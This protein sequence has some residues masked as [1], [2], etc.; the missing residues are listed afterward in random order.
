MKELSIKEIVI[1]LV[2]RIDPVG[3]TI[4][5][6]ARLEALKSLCSLVDDLVAEINSV[7]VCNRHSYESSRKIAADY[8][9]KFLADN[10]HDSINELKSK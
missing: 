3:E 2:G 6:A 1:K 4:T 9:Y 7:I 10:L 8:A 5:D